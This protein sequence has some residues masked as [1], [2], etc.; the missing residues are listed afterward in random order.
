[1]LTTLQAEE[2]AAT[3]VRD[4]G[5]TVSPTTGAPIL[6]GEWNR[7]AVALPTATHGWQGPLAEL[8]LAILT[9]SAMAGNNALG[10]WVDTETGV[11]YVDQVQL[12]SDKRTALGVA[13][14][15]NELAIWDGLEGA[16]VRL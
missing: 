8:P 15:R 10:T 4:G 11:A 16:E 13:A 7:Y 9:I 1:M 6:F 2:L 5:A 14:S 3:T 12:F